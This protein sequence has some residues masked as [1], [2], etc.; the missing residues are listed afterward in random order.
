M[1]EILMDAVFVLSIKSQLAG[2]WLMNRQLDTSSE[3]ALSKRGLSCF[4]LKI[5]I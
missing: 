4:L 1:R 3:D 2:G 5:Q